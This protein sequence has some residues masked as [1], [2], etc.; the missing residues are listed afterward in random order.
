[1]EP[2]ILLLTDSYKPTHWKQLPKGV[3]IL[4]SYLESRGGKFNN[5]LFYGLQYIIKKHLLGKVVTIE[6]INRAKL[7]WDA[8]IGP[9]HFNMEGWLHI[10]NK[11]NGHLPVIIKA[12]PEGSVIPT[13]N[14]L[15]TIENT[16]PEVPWLTNY[17]ESLLLQI[18]YPITVGTLSRE[19]KKVLFDYMI[20]TSTHDEETIRG[21]VK[22]MLHDFG[23]RGASSVESAG[24]GASAHIIN[25]KGSD[26]VEGVL[27]AQEYYNTV[28]M[29]AFSIPASEHSTITSW[30][31]PFEVKAFENMLDQFPTGIVACVSDSYNII[32]ACEEH[33]GT[34]LRNKILNRDGRLVI[35]P[36]S[37]DPVQTLKRIFHILWDKFG[38]TINN[39]GYK[40]IDPHVRVIQGDGVNYES[41]IEILDMMVDEKF[42]VE[43]IVFGMGGALLQKVDRDTQKF[44]IKCSSIVRDGVEVDVQKNPL[45]ID[46][47]GN[48][49][50]SFKKSKA[51]RLKLVRKSSNGFKY[52]SDAIEY[53]TIQHVEDFS[54]DI[55]TTIYENGVLL[56]EW[57]F[58][59]I[60][61]RAEVF[62]HPIEENI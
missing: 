37:G 14:V 25:F 62:S 33:W 22:F 24:I 34:T 59:E 5:T 44:A 61:E 9:G 12:V 20:K 48:M 15:L 55:L 27:L 57:T 16:D 35:R 36:D 53:D 30:T 21:M 50:Q 45:E 7:F 32:R 58:E 8:H 40:V 10:L 18:W 46:S 4:R 38:G 2:N 13:G 49:V 54:D 51:G 28:N 47:N 31:E 1:M 19:I 11:H 42:S 26:T 17:L 60:I 43:N 56:K 3:T 23:F 6:K 29:L 52:H 39:R 41:I